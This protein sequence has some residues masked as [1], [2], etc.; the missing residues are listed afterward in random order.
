MDKSCEKLI[1]LECKHKSAD[2]DIE[3]EVNL[4]CKYFKATMFQVRKLLMA[5]LTMQ[6][7]RAETIPNTQ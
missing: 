1:S 3:I 2:L 7:I 4:G 5:K 6:G